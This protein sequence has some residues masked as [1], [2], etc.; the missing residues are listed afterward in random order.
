L[1]LLI[2]V[3]PAPAGQRGGKVRADANRWDDLELPPYRDLP[4]LD[5]VASAWGVWGNDAALGC[6][7]L[8]TP[9]RVRE[10]S[11]LVER[12]AMFS[13]N[14]PMSWPDPPLFGRPPL[15]HEIGPLR[16][17]SKDETLH[18]WN[19]QGSS[20]WD[21]FR[22][23][24]RTGHGHFGGIPEAS[25]GVHTW[26]RHGIAGRAVLADLARWRESAGRPLH[27][28]Q[29]DPI[30]AHDLLDCLKAAGLT[31]RTGD[32]LLVRTG[33]LAWYNTLDQAGRTAV[34][35][36]EVL[37]SA[38]LLSGEE[39]AETLWD[40]HIAAVAADN[41]AL[42]VWPIGAN[43][44]PKFVAAVRAD[45]RREYQVQLHVRILAM[46]GIPIGELFDLEALAADC[47]ADGRY[48]CFFTSAP[49]NLPGGIASPPNALAFK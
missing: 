21:G 7:N 40:L 24:Q 30:D 20:Q 47:A 38:G 2:A 42:E 28:G 13:L 10:A 35:D 44:G 23:V 46:L 6:L 32:I 36:R 45:P 4:E 34:S 48:E 43:F 5:G 22:H 15:R 9:A 3:G 37:R 41:P 29:P 39:M 31:V 25:Q 27:P 8:L 49:I 19:T 14:L 33:W 17:A 16:N 18:G 11:R 12:G 1:G 26:S